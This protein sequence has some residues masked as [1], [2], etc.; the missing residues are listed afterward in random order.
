MG[1]GKVK[2]RSKMMDLLTVSWAV[3]EQKGVEEKQSVVSLGN[4]LCFVFV[5][6]GALLY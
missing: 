6:P 3:D 5:G 4:V 1:E 2:A